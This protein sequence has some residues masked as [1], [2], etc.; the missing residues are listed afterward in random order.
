[1]EYQDI[2][3]R[4]EIK[5]LIS[6]RQKKKILAAMEPYMEADSYGRSTICNIYYDTPDSILIRRSLEKPVYKEKLRVRSYGIASED[7]PVF[8]ELKKKY[9]GVV[10]KRRIS[11]SEEEAMT[12]LNHGAPLPRQNQITEEIDYF[13]SFYQNLA[14]AMLL[15]YDREAFYGKEDNNLRITFDENILW[16]DE[17]ISFCSEIY[18]SPILEKDYTLMEVKVAAAMPLWLTGIL[19]E[20]GIFKTTFSKYGN[21]YLQKLEGTTAMSFIA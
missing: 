1:M 6:A 2:F 17:N 4:Y 12:Y 16:R 9:K 5:Y 19:S 11:V 21:A 18:G 20:L 13:V 15:T 10:Y 8:V 14:P 3:K 7:S